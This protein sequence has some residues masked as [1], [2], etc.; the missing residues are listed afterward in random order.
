NKLPIAYWIKMA[1]M[2]VRRND[3][4]LKLYVGKGEQNNTEVEAWMPESRRVIYSDILLLAPYFE[5][6]SARKSGNRLYLQVA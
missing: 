1:Q 5:V 3:S 6:V 2:A 4:L